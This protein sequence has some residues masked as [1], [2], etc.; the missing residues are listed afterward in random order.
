MKALLKYIRIFFIISKK[1]FSW[2]K[3]MQFKILLRLLTRFQFYLCLLFCAITFLDDLHTDCLH[4][5]Y[6]V[7]FTAPQNLTFY[8][9]TILSFDECLRSC[10]QSPVCSSALW[11]TK[12]WICLTYE[13]IEYGEESKTTLYATRNCMIAG[14][15]L[16]K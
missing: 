1:N 11:N 13:N 4:N 12:S 14:N 10:D 3:I 2:I 15:A 9:Q 6:H 16:T 7:S 8:A 5:R